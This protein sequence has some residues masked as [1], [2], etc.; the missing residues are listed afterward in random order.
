[1]ATTPDVFTREVEIVNPQG[2]HARPVMQFVDVASQFQS[3]VTVTK[4]DQI[5]DGKSP[6]DMIVLEAT[7]GTGLTLTATGADAADAIEALTDLINRGF[8]EM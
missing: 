6:M 2:L 7:Q 4:G 5:V 3:V 8:D 1:M